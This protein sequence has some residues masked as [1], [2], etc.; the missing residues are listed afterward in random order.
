[1]GMA[2]LT[3]EY[4]WFMINIKLHIDIIEK[5]QASDEVVTKIKIERDLRSVLHT[6]TEIIEMKGNIIP[7]SNANLLKT[8]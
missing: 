8:T 2:S 1:M 6:T 5:A 7:T 3:L 4:E